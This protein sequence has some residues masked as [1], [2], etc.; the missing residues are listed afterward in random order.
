M[1]ADY[2]EVMPRGFARGISARSR[3]PEPAALLQSLHGRHAIGIATANLL[4][5]ARLRLIH[6]GL[7]QWVEGYAFGAEGGGHKRE[8]VARAIA[9][10]GLPRTRIVYIGDNLN[11]VDGRARKWCPLHRLLRWMPRERQ[12]LSA[13]GAEYTSGDHATTRD[14]IARL[15]SKD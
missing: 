3:L 12:R 7:W 10:T 13:A 6:A 5:A 8:T 1:I 14:M 9:A 4:A 15:L 11:D 2:L